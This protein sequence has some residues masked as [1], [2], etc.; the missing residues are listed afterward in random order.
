MKTTISLLLFFLLFNFSKAQ[1]KF[2]LTNAEGNPMNYY[3]SRPKSKI[4]IF[5]AV[6]DKQTKFINPFN[7]LPN[8]PLGNMVYLVNAKTIAVTTWIKKDSIDYY[9]YSIFENDTTIVRANAKLSQIDFVWP[10]S[11]D[12]PGYLTMNLTVPDTR[13]KKIT[14][15]IYR[16][17]EESKVTTV[18]I[19]NKSLPQA[20]IEK[21]VLL[22]E[23]RLFKTRGTNI[24]STL[25]D[26][27]PINNGSKFSLDKKSRG[28]Q[29]ILNKTDIDF[30]YY[31]GLVKVSKN[32][33]DT[34]FVSNNWNYDSHDGK[35][36]VF[37]PAS[38]FSEPGSYQ[39]RITPMPGQS[40]DRTSIDSKWAKISFKVKSPPLTF[41]IS[42]VITA[43][44]VI[45]LL[46]IS[47]FLLIRRKNKQKLIIA[48][49]QAESAKT[50]LNHVRSQLN[51]HF[52]F[53]ALGGIQNLM[54]Q[55]EIEK[56]NSYLSKFARLTR[57]IL[58][59]KQLIAL[60]DEHRLLDDYLAM[61]QLRFNFSYQIAVDTDIDILEVM[62]PTM[63]LQPFAENA[64]KH[65]MSVQG[66]KGKLLV[67]FKAVGDNL[68]LSVNDNG[69][70][71]DV[72]K[73][74]AGFGL[75]LCK[76][77]IDLL[78]RMYQDCP[79][80]LELHSDLN[81]TTAIITL[82]HWL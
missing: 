35:P 14:V 55:K 37:I 65:S 58:D 4:P 16:L 29:L 71:F 19:Y 52:V 75:S 3:V 43:L 7:A 57:S 1:E 42:E 39:L 47:T 64:V 67:A 28:I 26:I 17:P 80:T 34:L 51:P 30:A 79:I 13:N 62:I 72:Q 73:V 9:R 78:N 56:A 20:R 33:A 24:I 49:R 40:F 44:S 46:A 74:Y 27:I 63:L 32:K 69:E 45:I 31:A 8:D 50:E 54:N 70:G 10:A 81:G 38:Y 22:R 60:K 18:I 11:S 12:L 15:K 2:P 6:N 68:I 59:G 53:N 76:K 5:L 82:N 23:G 77:R 48:H 41:G 66:N 61:E 36:Y 25:A 21:A